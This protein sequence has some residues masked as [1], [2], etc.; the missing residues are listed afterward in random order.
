[1]STVEPDHGDG[2]RIRHLDISGEWAHYWTGEYMTTENDG[3]GPAWLVKRD[4]DG[5]HVHVHPAD[6]D[7]RVEH[8]GDRKGD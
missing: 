3:H 5:E 2:V 6:R 7:V 4:S 8:P 1:M